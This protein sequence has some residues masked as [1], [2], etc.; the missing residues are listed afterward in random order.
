MT[1]KESL[2]IEHYLCTFNATDAA[3]KAGYSE[4]TARQQ[5]Y[6]NLT[7]PYIQ[8]YIQ[9]KTSTILE[10]LGITQ[11]KVIRELA[12][13]AF[14]DIQECLKGKNELKNLNDICPETT[15]AIKNI[16]I[17][18]SGFKIDMH[19]KF[20]ALNKLVDLINSNQKSTY[21]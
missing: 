21:G 11:E 10:K 6:E 16:R 9:E 18:N 14:S 15:P 12:R 1:L 7:K 2:F 20:S 3:R 19:D 5:G 4:R 8:V 13:I 17:T